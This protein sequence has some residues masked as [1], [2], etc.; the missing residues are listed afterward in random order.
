MAIEKACNAQHSIVSDRKEPD[1]R[2][3]DRHLFE[4]HMRDAHAALPQRQQ[5]RL[6]AQRLDVRAR[7]LILH[8]QVVCFPW[9]PL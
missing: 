2:A 9:A 6:R 7:Q 4:V 1:L 8:G 3:D 5:A